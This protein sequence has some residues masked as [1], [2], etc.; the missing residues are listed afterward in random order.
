L[1]LEE[2]MMNVRMALLGAACALSLAGCYTIEGIGQDVARGGQAVQDAS[3][4]VRA[5]W[6]EARMRND[7]EYDAARA[8]CAG[9]SGADRDA[10]IDRARA[11]YSERMTD[12]RKTYPRS[13]LRTET[14]QDR[15]DDAYDAARDR[16]EQLRGA[17]EDRCI[18]DARARFRR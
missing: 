11:R 17:E 2:R 18:A 5:D 10:C 6:R 3:R 7:R 12:A 8:S 16:C 4:K 15:M 13:E 14:E 1:T 9:M